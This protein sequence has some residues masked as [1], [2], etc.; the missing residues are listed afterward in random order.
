ILIT[1]SAIVFGG[2]FLSAPVFRFIAETRIREMFTAFALLIVIAIAVL[3][4]AVGLSPALGTFLAGMV[5]AESE[6]RHELEADI[7]PFKGLLLGLF[8]ITVGASIDIPLFLQQPLLILG[9]VFA[10]IVIKLLVLLLLAKLFNMAFQQG[11]LF[12]VALAQGGEF[13]FLLIVTAAPY[14]IFPGEVANLLSL[15]IALSMLVSPLMLFAHE[16]F[17][18]RPGQDCGGP[19]DD[20]FEEDAPV[21]VAGYGRF[22]QIAGRLLAAQGF[23]LTI[24][25]H[26]P[27]QIELLRRYGSRV[28]YGDP[29]RMELLEAAGAKEAK[30]LIVAV[31]EPDKTLDIIDTAQKHFP[32]L[33]ILARAIDRRHTYELM[34]RDIAVIQRETFHSALNLGVDALK[35][36]GIEER[37]ANKAGKL[38]AEYDQQSLS[39]LADLWGDDHSYGVAVRQ[40]TED[41]KHVLNADQEEWDTEE[42]IQ[43]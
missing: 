14:G 34:K 27:S 13:G 31:D 7:E 42:A 3:M 39:V 24:L 26:S 30:L 10:L 29:S 33:K 19:E 18:S 2:E 16:R 23:E 37:R 36:L 5:L 21:I 43:D 11:T 4:Q 25:D 6:F 38:F 8:F 17:M 20:V 15:S 12:A 22:G 41:L 35:L 9:A 32:H 1:I 40:R 28:F